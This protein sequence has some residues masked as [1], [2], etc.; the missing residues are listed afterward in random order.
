MIPF[1]VRRQLGIL[2]QVQSQIHLKNSNQ[3]TTWVYQGQVH[4]QSL[5]SDQPLVMPVMSK[6]QASRTTLFS[7]G[8]SIELKKARD[9]LLKSFVE[10][11]KIAMLEYTWSQPLENNQACRGY[12][13]SQGGHSQS[14]MLTSSKWLF[15]SSGCDQVHVPTIKCKSHAFL[16]SSY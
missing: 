12:D 8:W 9:L 4:N 11:K 13:P 1:R 16:T 14:S 2:Y 3:I 7:A 5:V 6:E 10:L 15:T